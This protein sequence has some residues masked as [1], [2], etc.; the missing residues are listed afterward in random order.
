[1]C[2]LRIFNGNNRR[3]MS[4]NQRATRVFDA[5]IIGSFAVCLRVGSFEVRKN[6][7]HHLHQGLHSCRGV[8]RIVAVLLTIV[9]VGLKY[10]QGKW[11]V[12][13]LEAGYYKCFRIYMSA[14]PKN[15]P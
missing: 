9:A 2:S 12:L 15:S 5:P 7:Y 8:C 11:T 6:L 3:L 10:V 1:M 4:R 13:S 14:G